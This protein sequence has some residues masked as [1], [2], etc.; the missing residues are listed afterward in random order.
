MSIIDKDSGNLLDLKKKSKK[1]LEF[2]RSIYVLKRIQ[3]TRK[4]E[5]TF[6]STTCIVSFRQ[7]Q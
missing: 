6:T 3:T 1:S 5:V 2:T 4:P 7:T